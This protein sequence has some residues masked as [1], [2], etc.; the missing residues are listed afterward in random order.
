MTNINYGYGEPC[1]TTAQN[2]SPPE[3]DTLAFLAAIEVWKARCFAA[4]KETQML[5]DAI[6]DL[7]RVYWNGA[8]ADHTKV[9]AACLGLFAKA[10][11]VSN[12][13]RDHAT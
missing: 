10:L 12:G 9:G 5:R 4:E 13:E 6:R 8:D 2:K 1:G 11:T 7:H 3:Q